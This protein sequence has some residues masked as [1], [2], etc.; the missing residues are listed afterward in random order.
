MKT[1]RPARTVERLCLVAGMC[2]LAYVV[3]S[4]VCREAYQIYLTYTFRSELPAIS[5]GAPMAPPAEG[6]PVARLEIPRLKLSVIVLEGVADWTLELGAG[7]IPGTSLPGKR[8]NVGIAA[9]R[10]TFFRPLE[11]IRNGDMI[12]LTTRD[13]S[14]DYAVE[15]TQIVKPTAVDVL[16]P[17]TQPSLTLVTCYPF[18]YVG[19]A[20]DRFVVRARQLTDT[21]PSPAA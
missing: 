15:W 16:H 3:L 2:L 9:H 5:G 17:T 10:D 12:R 4:Y 20:P 21:V 19:S 8:G 1:Q 18:Y 7:R 14:Y 11:D 6:M 13:G